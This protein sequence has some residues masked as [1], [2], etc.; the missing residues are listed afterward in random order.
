MEDRLDNY[1]LSSSNPF[2][3]GGEDGG[4]F[5]FFFN[6]NNNYDNNSLSLDGFYSNI[7]NTSEHVFKF[8]SLDQISSIGDHQELTGVTQN[9]NSFKNDCENINLDTSMADCDFENHIALGKDSEKLREVK[10]QKHI[11]SNLCKKLKP[12]RRDVINKTIFRIIRRYFHMLLEKAIPDYKNQKKNNLMKMLSSFSEFLFPNISNSDEMAKVMSALMFRREVLVS[13]KDVCKDASLKVFLD[14]Q[15]K[16]SHKLLLPALSNPYFREMFARFT[17]QGIPFL[18]KDE[19]VMSN[20]IIYYKELEKIKNI[21]GSLS[22][23]SL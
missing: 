17:K 9:I 8:A 19:N 7:V 2:K 4:E 18:D 15:S 3:S 1:D 12:I 6:D 14:I 23:E 5:Q 16:Y 20:S 21:F 10:I 22:Q 11:S 13:Q